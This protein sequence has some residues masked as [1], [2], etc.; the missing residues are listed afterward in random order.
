MNI[1]LI[2]LENVGHKKDMKK[3]M[4]IYLIK[5]K[6][7]IENWEDNPMITLETCLE[8]IQDFK[9]ELRTSMN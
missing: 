4:R 9:D 8:F 3:E 2:F 5:K 1:F 7:E 6:I